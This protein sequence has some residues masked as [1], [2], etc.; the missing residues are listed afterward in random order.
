MNLGI[1]GV[2]EPISPETFC[3]VS[4]IILRLLIARGWGE[5]RRPNP[6]FVQGSTILP[7]LHCLHLFYGNRKGI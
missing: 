7:S 1:Q 2:P 6:G 4:K 5:G 3:G